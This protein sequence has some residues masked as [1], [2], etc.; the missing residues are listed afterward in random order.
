MFRDFRN[1]V[2]FLIFYCVRGPFEGSV[3]QSFNQ[4]D[5]DSSLSGTTLGAGGGMESKQDPV[6]VFM[7]L[8][9]AGVG[10]GGIT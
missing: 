7:Q 8:L 2:V 10:W 4:D 6:L 1:C 3:A 5:M 9:V